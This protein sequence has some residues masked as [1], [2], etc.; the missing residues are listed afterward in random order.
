[1]KSIAIPPIPHLQDFALTQEFD[2]LLSHLFVNHE[3]VEFYRRK[4]QALADRCFYILDNSAHEM[5]TGQ[6][7]ELL[8]AQARSI[9]ASEIVLPDT[10]FDSERTVERSVQGMVDLVSERELPFTLAKVMVVPQGTT[11]HEYLIC[12]D[13]LLRG[14]YRTGLETRVGLTIGISKDYEEKFPDGLSPI[15]EKIIRS[16]DLDV[17][18][19]LLGWPIPLSR[20]SETSIRFGS[21]IRS[22]DT[23]RMFTYAMNDIRLSSSNLPKYPKRPHDFFDRRLT[24]EQLGIAKDNVEFY[25]GLVD[26]NSL[27]V[28]GMSDNRTP[29]PS[30]PSPR[31]TLSSKSSYP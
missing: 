19:H 26:A 27:F 6:S 8:L 4:K 29:V 2:L 9:G 23:A 30:V 1:M 5:E 11:E 24:P 3:Y 22:T 16:I 18:I 17:E 14:F 28:G 10:L 15:L 25:R 31:K 7:L 13:E 12:F 21:R 20:L